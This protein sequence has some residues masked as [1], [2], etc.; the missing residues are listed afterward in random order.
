M[1]SSFGPYDL[2]TTAHVADKFGV[3]PSTLLKWVRTSN[4]GFP[5]PVK[6]S[7]RYY[8]DPL[9]VSEWINSSHKKY[10]R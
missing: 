8:F 10:I 3:N 6:I 5:Q 1:T 7:G 4:L 2:L 9:E